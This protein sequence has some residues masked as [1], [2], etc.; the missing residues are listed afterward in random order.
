MPAGEFTTAKM[1]GTEKSAFVSQT[2]TSGTPPAMPAMGPAVT[3]FRRWK[4]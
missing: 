3:P 4:R 1:V 2:S